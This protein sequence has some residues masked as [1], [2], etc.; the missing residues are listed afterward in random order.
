MKK[1]IIIQILFCFIQIANAQSAKTNLKEFGLK[2]KVKEVILYEYR[3]EINKMKVD[4]LHHPFKTIMKFDEKGNL[5]E[6]YTF[7]KNEKLAAKTLYDYKKDGSIT[8]NIFD[9]MNK[10]L[11]SAIL[12]YDSIGRQIESDSYYR[13][14]FLKT[15]YKYDEAGNQIE[16]ANY[17][18]S[19]SLTIKYAYA[20]NE[21][22][23]KVGQK[24]YWH[25]G[26]QTDESIFKYDALGNL[27]KTETYNLDGKIV[28]GN[29]AI[30]TNI[31]KDGNWL[32]EEFEY[33][34]HSQMQGD[35]LFKH[36]DKRVIEY[37]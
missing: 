32:S 2:G 12:K 37:Y 21:K 13:I 22:N 31:D 3:A 7:D 30:Y 33:T 17:L 15:V 19:G 24:S 18:Q 16:E 4:T 35:F 23:Q 26:K 1:L 36:V 29:T 8:K 27:I 11:D 25:D 28:G 9:P 34:G 20:F 6:E 14:N 10:L 5:T